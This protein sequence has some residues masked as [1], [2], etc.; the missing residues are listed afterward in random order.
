MGEDDEIC[1]GRS[2]LEVGIIA[3]ARFEV[4][5]QIGPDSVLFTMGW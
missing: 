4:D 5:H 2:K 3:E 1:F